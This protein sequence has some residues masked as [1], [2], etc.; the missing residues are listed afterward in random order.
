MPF[1]T[2]LGGFW[3]KFG[4]GLGGQKSTFS[5]QKSLKLRIQEDV[6]KNHDLESILEAIKKLFP[7]RRARPKYGFRIGGVHFFELFTSRSW[8]LK[9]EALERGLGRRFGLGKRSQSGILRPA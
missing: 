6:A 3:Q 4:S 5:S 9:K 8:S 1:G 7:I 2:D